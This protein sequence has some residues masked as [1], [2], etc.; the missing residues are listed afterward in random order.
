M[1]AKSPWP[2]HF[3]KAFLLLVLLLAIVARLCQK[4]DLTK[5]D[6]GRHIKN[7]EI[8]F[9]QG[10]LITTNHYSYTEPQKAVVNH[11]W[12][13]GFI[14]YLI[15]RRFGFEGLSFFY[16]LLVVIS[17]LLIFRVG[18]KLSNFSLAYFCSVVTLPFFISRTEVRPE[19]LSYLLLSLYFFLLYK[20]KL[21][22]YKSLC[23]WIIPFLQMVW[24]NLHSFFIFGLVLVAAF[25]GDALVNGKD[26]RVKKQLLIIFLI[27]CLACLMNPFGFKG[28][29]LPL[30]IF[31]EM[32]FS[33][34]EHASVFLRRK[35]YPH[36]SFYFYFELIFF[37]YVILF[38]LTFQ[39]KRWIREDILPLTIMGV[40]SFLAFKW[41]R[42]MALFGFFCTPFL[43]DRM[44]AFIKDYPQTKGKFAGLALATAVLLLLN[45]TAL[46]IQSHFYHKSFSSVT[47]A[48]ENKLSL[49]SKFK[50]FKNIYCSGGLE[51][52]SSNSAVF[53]KNQNLR[54]PI[55]NNYDIGGYLIFHLFPQERVFVDNRPEAYSVSFFR[56]I[57]I[58][59]QEDETVW[60]KMND[61][62]GFNI[63]YFQRQDS[64]RRA[65]LFL[66]RRLQDPQ[67]RLIYIDPYAIILLK[68]QQA[69]K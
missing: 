25:L 5:S 64:T 3:G 54:G 33:V 1:L 51:P 12:G 69:S 11:H 9:Q 60:Q 44:H 30:T 29:F 53:F 62:F 38:L 2:S 66:R 58:P 27:S 13:S 49:W 7:G 22:Q 56:D 24:V 67:W 8:L 68:N 43:A 20:Y 15:F 41:I 19:G 32:V 45:N 35:I 37:I 39:K 14:F 65:K 59:M 4:I 18:V 40:F 28:A 47:P 21:G 42:M 16:I 10:Q 34:S 36:D 17:F 50:A 61:R 26:Q 48:G 55:F 46:R 23:L 63:I 31:H 52:D 6:L 57:Y